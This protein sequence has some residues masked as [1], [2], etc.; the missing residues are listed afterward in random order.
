VDPTNLSKEGAA[1]WEAIAD[2]WAELM[3]TG[4]GPAQSRELVLDASHWRL[5]GDVS[6]KRVLDAGCGE[7]RFARQLAERGCNVAAVDLS[8]Q[9]I[10]NALKREAQRPLGIEYS[11]ADMCDLSTFDDASF[12][13][14]LSYLS[15]IDVEDYA[16]ATREIARVMKPGGQFLFSIVHPCFA[17]PGAHWEPKKPGTIPVWDRDKLYKKIDNY[18]PAREVRF[19]MWPT[20]P[21]LTV[22]WHRPITD[23]A[24]TLRN[25]GFLI[26]DIDEPVPADDVF[27]R[28][29]DLREFLRAPYFMVFDCVKAR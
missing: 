14:A 16:S 9:M 28:R 11:V 25:A 4:N 23:Y 19:K 7:G 5:L 2:G 26:R 15:L 20:A 29:D 8:V 22:N 13:V 1:S 21:A 24:A 18:F 3:A 6:G 17:P 12:D 27:D 10:H